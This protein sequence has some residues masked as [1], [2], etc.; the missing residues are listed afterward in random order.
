M[1][2]FTIVWAGQ[3]V[4]VLTSSM[5]QFAIT[6]WAFQ[7]TGSAVVLGALSTV[8]LVPFLLIS[9]FAGVLVDRHNRKLMM[10]VSDLAAVCA[11]TGI[12]IMNLVGGLQIWHLYIATA[13]IGLGN[14]FQWPAYSAA[15]TTMV[16][17]EKYSRANG[18]MSLVDSGPQVLAPLLAGAL[19]P[20]IAFTG[21]LVLDVVTFFIAIATLLAVKVPQPLQTSEGQEGRGNLFKEAAYGFRYI[22][23]R[24]SLLGLLIFFVA[25]NF[26]IGLSGSVFSPFILLRTENN[27]AAL[28]V[29]QS[30][31]AIGAV[32]GGLLVSLWGGFKRRMKSILIGEALTGLTGM[33][34]FGLGRDLPAWIAT[35]LVASVFPVF[36]NG[37]SQ[38]I[39]QSKVAP[40]VQGRV[41]SARRM[42]AWSVNP[43]TPIL[44]CALAD[45]VTEPAMRS[46]SWLANLFGGLV[47]T[48]PG[49][50]IAVQ[51]ILT[52][53]AYMLIVGV[54]FLFFPAVRDL[55]DRLPD[56]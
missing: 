9:P 26:T 18:M 48:T 43:V 8:F 19:L 13:V 4:S 42:I 6:I 30:A 7:E 41:F 27:S 32:V 2:G 28:G 55:E 11:T 51:F 10:M 45:Y 22:F 21:I 12:L 49:S 50:G 56:Y 14:A 3:L 24:R 52:G 36:V 53:V 35:V 46:G 1:A 40:D 39:W 31:A 54:V 17:K 44:A 33:V 38:A 23:A 34:L 37:A 29:V 25:L 5:T 47:G 15:I 16:P 20:V